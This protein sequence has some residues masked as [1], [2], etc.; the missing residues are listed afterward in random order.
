LP[1]SAWGIPSPIEGESA[2]RVVYLGPRAR[3]VLQPW[4]EAART[5][6][7]Y[8]FARRGRLSP[9]TR[10]HYTRLIATAARAAGVEPWHPHQLRHARGTRVRASHGLDAAQAE[11]GHGQ[12]S[13]T[14]RYAAPDDE[15]ARR[16][17]EETG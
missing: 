17:A 16:A 3:A 6:D 11:L 8:L 14:E 13:T 15:A 12:A 4:L 7:D 10:R 5:P 1:T 9:P 2:R